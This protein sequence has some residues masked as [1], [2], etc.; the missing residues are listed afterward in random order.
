MKRETRVKALQKISKDLI[1]KTEDVVK[2]DT[3][4]TKEETTKIENDKPVEDKKFEALYGVLKNTPAGS[5]EITN[6]KEFDKAVAAVSSDILNTFKDQ[7][8]KDKIVTAFKDAINAKN[9]NELTTA[10]NMIAGYKKMQKDTEK[11]AFNLVSKT[12]IK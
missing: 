4:A 1:N 3:P 7:P 2:E 9:K 11:Q 10:F 12:L 8:N 5:F 6:D